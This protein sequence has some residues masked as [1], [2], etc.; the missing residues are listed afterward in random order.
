MK[1]LLQS[2][3]LLLRSAI[4][5]LELSF[6]SRPENELFISVFIPLH[7]AFIPLHLGQFCDLQTHIIHTCDNSDVF[8]A[9]KN[10][11]KLLITSAKR[12]TYLDSGCPW[13]AIDKSQFTKA[14]SFTDSTYVFTVH[15]DL[16]STRSLIITMRLTF[17]E[18]SSRADH[19]PLKLRWGGQ[20]P[21]V[22]STGT[23]RWM[24]RSL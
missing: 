2:K 12:E 14:S 1:W 15:V 7:L 23:Y 4:K 19:A 3:L 6:K 11:T 24:D 16:H 10:I 21:N 8:Q 18:K 20:L 13:S 9:A 17:T 22:E 5:T